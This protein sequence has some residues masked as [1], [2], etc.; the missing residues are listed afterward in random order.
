MTGSISVIIP[1]LN[2]G[3]RLGG[4]LSGLAGSGVHEVIVA[5][6][7]STDDTVDIARAHG[8]RIV[9]GAPGRGRQMNAGAEVAAGE[10]LLFL[11]ADTAM[12]DGFE[13]AVE[14]VLSRQGVVAGAFRLRVD[15]PQWTYRMAE[16][17]VQWRS[18][19]LQM[20][21]GDQAL[22]IRA[23][24]FREIGGYRPIPIMEDY[25]LVRRLR[26]SGRIGIADAEVVTSARRWQRNGFWRTAGVNQVCMVAYLLGVS[27]D[28][29]ARWRG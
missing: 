13:L 8:A 7:E 16:G 3:P 10:T 17:L 23:R 28:R 19:S 22:F 1:T 4:L 12:P 15:A 20:P 26:R 21:Y 18:R 5:D 11:H 29:L 27:P 25:E 14:Q 6:G 9:T 24:R 2:E